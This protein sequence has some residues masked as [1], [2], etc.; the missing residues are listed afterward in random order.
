[1]G[2]D[3]KLVDSFIHH[4][5]FV[6]KAPVFVAGFL[7][8]VG[9]GVKV[10]T[11][12]TILVGDKGADFLGAGI[13]RENSNVPAL[14]RLAGIGLFVEPGQALLLV[15]PGIYGGFTGF[16]GHIV[17]AQLCEPIIVLRGQLHYGVPSQRKIIRAGVAIVIG[18]EVSVGVALRISHPESPAAKLIAGV[19]R[20]SMR[21]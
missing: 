8:P 11:S 10:I 17:E 4:P 14:H 12:S 2:L 6:L 13:I 7:R 9:A 15:E 21:P 16:H 3:I 19:L 18:G 1:M 5:V 20:I